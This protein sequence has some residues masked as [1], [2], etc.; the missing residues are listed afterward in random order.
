MCVCVWGGGGGGGYC[1]GL[2]YRIM[3]KI[4]VTGDWSQSILFTVPTFSTSL[5][6]LLVRFTQTASCSS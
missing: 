6:F 5:T 2:S 4:L 3:R 1:S